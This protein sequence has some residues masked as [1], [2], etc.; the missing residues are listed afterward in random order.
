MLQS[1]FFFFIRLMKKKVCNAVAI[2]CVLCSDRNSR[3]KNDHNYWP[4][5]HHVYCY[6]SSSLWFKCSLRRRYIFSFFFFLWFVHWY[7]IRVRTSDP[8]CKRCIRLS[9]GSSLSMVFTLQFSLTLVHLSDDSISSPGLCLIQFTWSSTWTGWLIWR[10]LGVLS[11]K[12]MQPFKVWV[13]VREKDYQT[14][15]EHILLVWRLKFRLPFCLWGFC[16]QT[17]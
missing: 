6:F 17:F 8:C 14:C 12:Q 7:T 15:F 4:S 13:Q 3:V 1:L 2:F 11:T 16:L 9:W 5:E 10:P